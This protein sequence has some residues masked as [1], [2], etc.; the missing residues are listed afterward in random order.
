MDNRTTTEL[1]RDLDELQRVLY[2]KRA[3]IKR[4]APGKYHDATV[5]VVRRHRVSA[6]WRQKYVAVRLRG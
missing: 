2:G 4:R 6:H 1:L 3:A 5:Y